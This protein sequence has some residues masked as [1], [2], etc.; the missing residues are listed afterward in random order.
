MR[1]GAL[2]LGCG[3]P[4]PARRATRPARRPA[5]RAARRPAARTAARRRR[6]AGTRRAA[7]WR[8]ARARARSASRTTRVL[9]IPASPIS[10]VTDGSPAS[11]R[12]SAAPSISSSARAL[13]EA[14]A[15]DPCAHAPDYGVPGSAREDR[16]AV[17]GSADGADRPPDRCQR[18]PPLL[19][20]VRPRHRPRHLRRAG[21]P[22]PLLLR[23]PAHRP[24][25]HGLRAEGVRDR[26]RR[27][28]VRGGRAHAGR[29]RHRAAGRLPA[30]P[31][32]LRGRAGARGPRGAVREPP[33]LRLARRR[34][35][36]RSAP[37]TCATTAGETFVSEVFAGR[38]RA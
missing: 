6:G 31:L 3:P 32:R 7:P 19:D 9:P 30:R 27:R 36:R 22:V 10:S 21:L 8:R 26:D 29:L 38:S 4:G 15:G 17:V 1:E 35:R 37:S 14:V 18:V 28:A 2:E 23:R 16:C 24:P 20:A 11:A 5:R 12:S 34:P 13:D 33:L 25:L